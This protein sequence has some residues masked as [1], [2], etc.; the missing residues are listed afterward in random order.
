[1]NFLKSAS[2]I[3]SNFY[4]DLLFSL[5]LLFLILLSLRRQGLKL[6]H[7]LPGKLSQLKN[8]SLKGHFSGS[9]FKSECRSSPVA[10]Q[11]KD[12]V[13][14]LQRLRLL[15]WC[16]FDLWP[17]NFHMLLVYPKTKSKS[18]CR[19]GA[20]TQMSSSSCLVSTVQCFHYSSSFFWNVH[21]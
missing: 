16:G 10:Q 7:I 20:H 19:R 12:P 8:K 3:S 18:E 14:S 21:Y 4:L 6:Q 9:W 13:L 15:L 2:L 17:G 1:M 11:V 5:T